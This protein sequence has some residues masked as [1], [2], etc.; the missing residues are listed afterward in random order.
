[1]PLRILVAD[2]HHVLRSYTT[3]I[4]EQGGFEVVGEAVDGRELVEFAR[5]LRPDIAILDASL[6]RLK[7]FAAARQMLSDS[8]W[9]S[10]IL[11]TLHTEAPYVLEAFRVGIRG[12]V[13]KSHVVEDLT[14][15]VDQVAEGRTY[16]SRVLPHAAL[17]AHAPS[18][19]ACLDRSAI[20][21]LIDSSLP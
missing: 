18:P 9:M 20:P 11:L 1:M 15:A 17:R 8:P 13:V 21:G 7:G 14:E 5:R 10:L 6:P 4:L 12:F 19:R 2:G 16:A 3:A